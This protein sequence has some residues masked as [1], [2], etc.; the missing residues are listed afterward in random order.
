VVRT[1]GC[2]AGSPDSNPSNSAS[3]LPLTN[4]AARSSTLGCRLA[5]LTPTATRMTVRSMVTASVLMV[6]DHP[7]FRDELRALLDT[8]PGF[9]LVAGTPLPRPTEGMLP[10]LLVVGVGMSLGQEAERFF[11]TYPSSQ[12]LMAGRLAEDPWPWPHIGQGLLIAAIF[13]GVATVV[14]RRTSVVNRT[15]G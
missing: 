9:G 5:A 15:R 6:H 1:G 2:G 4:R 10:V 12:L 7:M 8:V 3:G 13:V 14:Q 11:F